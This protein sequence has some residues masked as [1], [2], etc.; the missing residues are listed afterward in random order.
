MY[1]DYSRGLWIASNLMIF[2]DKGCSGRLAQ[3][4]LRDGLQPLVEMW[5][6]TYSETSEAKLEEASTNVLISKPLGAFKRYVTFPKE[7]EGGKV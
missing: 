2:P 4:A 3:F 5:K 6:R 7:K 1:E